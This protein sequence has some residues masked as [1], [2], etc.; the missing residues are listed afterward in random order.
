MVAVVVGTAMMVVICSGV[1]EVEEQWVGV[2]IVQRRL[3]RQI[4]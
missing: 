1:M 4:N 2:H 3:C